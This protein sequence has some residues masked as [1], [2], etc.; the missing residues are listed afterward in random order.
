MKEVDERKAEIA[1][2]IEKKSQSYLVKDGSRKKLKFR[3][4]IEKL[5]V[6][7]LDL[8]KFKNY[9]IYIAKNIFIIILYFM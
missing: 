6:C 8:K 4:E 7:N 2:E 5:G 1:A 9:F 3:E